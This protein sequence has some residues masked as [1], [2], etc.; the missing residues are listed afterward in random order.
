MKNEI[1]ALTVACLLPW[2]AAGGMWLTTGESG[3]VM[4]AV[5]W[6]VLSPL[7]VAAIAYVAYL[8]GT[9]FGRLEATREF[10]RRKID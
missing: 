8:T 4:A 3:A 9:L 5:V 1:V 6:L 7:A 10:S 2:F